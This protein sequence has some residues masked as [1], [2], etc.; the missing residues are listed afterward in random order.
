MYVK[1]G[2]AAVLWFLDHPEA[3]GLYNV[4]AGRARTFNDLA[5]AIFAALGQPADVQYVPTP[6][7]I[8]AAYQYHTEADLTRLR[9]VG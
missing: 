9:S 7:N 1:E 5:S 3:Q 8:R 2:C 4:G 6:E